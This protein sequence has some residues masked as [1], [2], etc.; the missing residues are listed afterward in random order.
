MV[1]AVQVVLVINFFI[2]LQSFIFQTLTY[3]SL[4]LLLLLLVHD[5][6]Y[7]ISNYFLFAVPDDLS[8][9]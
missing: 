4:S 3:F 1:Y 7:F 2:F 5:V 9:M 6:C 8:D